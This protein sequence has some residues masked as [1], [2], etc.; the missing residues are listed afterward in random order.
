MSSK[1]QNPPADK[2]SSPKKAINLCDQYA[3]KRMLDETASEVILSKGYVEN[4]TISNV[5]MGIGLVACGIALIAQFYPKKF[6]ANK[7]ILV[8][9]IVFYAFFH[10]LL[11]LVLHLK[12]KNHIL[13]THPLHGSFSSTGLA[14][15][16][17]LPRYSDLYT[18]QIVSSDPKSI[19]ANPPVEFTESVTQWFTKDGFLIEGTFRETVEKLLADYHKES[20]KTK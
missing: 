5:K 2:V 10:I 15:S 17:K 12:E 6:P 19:A 4:V 3:V 7:N 16:S 8:T 20:R 11:Q 18:L 13:F 1:V 9:C 14:V